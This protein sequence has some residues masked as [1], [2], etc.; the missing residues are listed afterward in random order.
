MQN[1]EYEIYSQ[2]DAING[3]LE[4]IA[5]ALELMVGARALNSLNIVP[6]SEVELFDGSK[7]VQVY[8]NGQKE[9][10]SSLVKAPEEGKAP[11]PAGDATTTGNS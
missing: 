9:E 5:N 8:C 11:G 2:L 1:I 10:D 3:N 7:A 4:R 6:G